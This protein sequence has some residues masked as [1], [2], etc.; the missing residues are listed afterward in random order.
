MTH[1]NVGDKAPDFNLPSHLGGQIHLEELRGK[2][3]VI[4]FFPAAFTPV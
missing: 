1:L 4:V 3:V 2:N